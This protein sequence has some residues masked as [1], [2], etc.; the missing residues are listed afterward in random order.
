MS[1]CLNSIPSQRGE[2]RPMKLTAGTK[3]NQYEIV[4]PL[5]AGG[6]GEVYRARDTK[7]NREVALKVLPD[8]FAVD[9]ERLAR[10]KREAQVLASLNHPNIGHIYGFEDSG[11]THVLVLIEGPTL[12]DR[13]AQGPIAVPDALL[14]AKQ[15]ADALEAAHEHGIVHRD[16]KPANIKVRADGTVKVLDFGL[17]KATE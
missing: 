14:I 5:G 17:A 4:A 16:L 1:I 7:L 2:R 15:I 12:A 8:V 9:L 10:F 3:L 6:M 13:I 11:A